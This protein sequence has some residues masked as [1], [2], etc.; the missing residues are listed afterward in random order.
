R[1]RI[2]IDCANGAAS[3]LAARVFGSIGAEL[4]VINDR[5]D[6][7]NINLGCG[8]LHLEQL[9]NAV[10]DANAGVGIAFDGDADRALFVDENGNVVDGD[11]V[12]WIMARYLKDHGRLNGDLVVS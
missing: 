9:K 5:P 8:S 6:G 1:S 2:V 3:Q 11:A 4:V 7:R 12:M 10:L